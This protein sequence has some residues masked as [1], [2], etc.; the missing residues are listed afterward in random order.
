MKLVASAGHVSGDASTSRR[1]IKPDSMPYVQ[2]RILEHKMQ[3][4]DLV[5][6]DTSRHDSS[7]P[8]SSKASK[9]TQLTT[10]NT[11]ERWGTQRAASSTSVPATL[12][13]TV[14]SKESAEVLSASDSSY[15][16]SDEE[17]IRRERVSRIFREF[18]PCDLESLHTALLISCV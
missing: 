11:G 6:P 13:E 15:S 18:G 9:S 1:V 7:A 14:E 2:K 10:V 4:P 12:G 5:A 16:I 3:S 8:V 17:F